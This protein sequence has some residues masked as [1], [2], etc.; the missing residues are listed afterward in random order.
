MSAR[1]RPRACERL[2]IL[3]ALLG[4]W[5]ALSSS[6]QAAPA[7]TP[8]PGWDDGA[9]ADDQARRRADAWADAWGADL[10][11]VM[12]T[13][14]ADDFAETLAV[15][16]VASPIP[17]EA[18]AG[19]EA[20]RTWLEPRVSAAFGATATLDPERLEL[21]SRPQPGVAVLLARVR[22]GDRIARVAMAPHGARHLA[23]VLLVPEAE[24]VLHA[25]AFDDVVAGLDGLAPPI[26]PFRLGL[27]RGAAWLAW[28]LV[29]GAFAFEWARRSLPLPGARVAG[30]QV[31][32]ALVLVALLVLVLAGSLLGDAAVELALAG[33]SPWGL[34]LELGLGGAVAAGV[35][36]GGTELWERR[37][38]PVASAPQAGSFA[39]SSPVPQRRAA[40]PLSAPVPGPVV[41]GDTH[42]GRAPAVTGDTHVGRPPAI[43][44]D[45]QV[46]RA[47]AI[48]GDTQVGR[49]PAI[50][51]DTQVG[52]APR[53]T[54]DTKVGP[55]PRPI[56]VED[57]DA[58][59][60]VREIISGDIESDT[61]VRRI[62]EPDTVKTV[63]PLRPAIAAVELAADEDTNPRAVPGQGEAPASL[64]PPPGFTSDRV[65]PHRASQSDLFPRADPERRPSADDKHPA[66]DA[67]LPKLEIDW[68]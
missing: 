39:I 35:V 25:R 23:V 59:P 65:Q 43:T 32:V 64:A 40:S 54:G 45:T 52:R 5:L 34:A 17:A 21:R 11:R 9:A 18:L 24:E 15:L 51:G 58:G 2:V 68:S 29:G 66:L 57:F 13:R 4:L 1:E 38:G 22:V 33:S 63:P 12:S 67:P 61:Q 26:A 10:R 62:P 48:T 20:G 55:P 56:S 27:V 31:A 37:I 6:I 14:S 42:V 36:L 41:T 49:A 44:G 46:G 16:D 28:L 30:R 8:P 50:T 19:L 47:P 60:P 7:F 53:I 3:V